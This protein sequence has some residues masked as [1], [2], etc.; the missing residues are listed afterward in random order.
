[1]MQPLRLD[2]LQEAFSTRF[3]A[4]V[5]CEKRREAAEEIDLILDLWVR[6]KTSDQVRGRSGRP[7]P[8]A[9]PSASQDQNCVPMNREWAS[10]LRTRVRVQKTGGEA[11][12]G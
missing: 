4:H 9:S 3:A 12:E 5:G 1:M 10:A 6:S 8:V 11:E 2:R 7:E